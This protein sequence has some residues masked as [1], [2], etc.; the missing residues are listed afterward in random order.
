MLCRKAS[1]RDRH[2]DQPMFRMIQPLRDKV[3][4]IV[5]LQPCD[6]DKQLRDHHL[7]RYAILSKPSSPASSSTGHCQAQRHGGET[8]CCR[9]RGR[10]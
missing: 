9:S 6:T 7:T 8:S 5:M 2:G 4:S 10:R 3:T 1:G